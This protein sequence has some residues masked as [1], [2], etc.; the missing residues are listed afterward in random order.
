[1]KNTILKTTGVLLLA[2]YLAVAGLLWRTGNPPKAYRDVQVVV[3]DSDVAQFVDVADIELMLKDQ[4]NPISKSE[5]E[6]STYQLQQLLLSNSLIQKA[7]CYYTPDS[8]MR[9]DIYQRHPILR[10]KGESSITDAYVD[11]DG[12]LM[13]YKYCRKA[14]DVPLATGYVDSLKAQGDLYELAK[15]LH[16]N[17]FWN[18]AITQIYVEK[19]GDI[20]LIPRVGSHTILLG[21]SE[22][23]SG[24]FENLKK[25]YQKVLNKHGWNTYSTINLKFA[26]QVVAEKNK[27]K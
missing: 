11:T 27:K 20:R 8:M 4:F 1:M 23:L 24:K 25:F 18:D 7:Y 5:S 14:V 26:N 16:Q 2:I 10:I 22:N 3:C 13:K 21:T 17:P 6:Y 12:K 19:N 15:F 9:V